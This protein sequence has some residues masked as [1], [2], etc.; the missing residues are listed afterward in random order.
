[1]LMNFTAQRQYCNITQF[2]IQVEKFD[3]TRKQTH[4]FHES[5]LSKVITNSIPQ[6]S[7]LSRRTRHNSHRSHRIFLEYSI[8][9]LPSDHEFVQNSHAPFVYS[10]K[11]TNK[12]CPFECK[13]IQKSCPCPRN[14]YISS[15][16]SE[17]LEKVSY[18]PRS[19]VY[20]YTQLAPCSFLSFNNKR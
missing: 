17:Y 14:V 7:G 9:M 20:P 6:T 11:Y 13:V 15:N 19:E 2:F 1:M 10:L 18:P 4:V 8:K 16:H 3:V 12:K 5:R